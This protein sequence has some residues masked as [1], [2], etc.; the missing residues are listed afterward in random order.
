MLVCDDV[1]LARR[2]ASDVVEA[3]GEFDAEG[4]G[5][6][7]AGRGE[8]KARPDPESPSLESPI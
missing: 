6:G 3:V 5:P 1:P 7:A 8:Q 4:A 2:R